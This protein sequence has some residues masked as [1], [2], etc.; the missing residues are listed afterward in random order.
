MSQYLL[1]HLSDD[2]LTNELAT[3]T[4][5]ARRCVVRNISRIA[6]YDR[7]Q[8]YLAVGYKSMYRY[9]IG[10][11]GLSED[12]AFQRIRVGR[13]ALEFPAIFELLAAGQVNPTTVLLAAPH[14]TPANAA[15]LLAAITRRTIKQVRQLLADRF[16]EAPGLESDLARTAPVTA[17]DQPAPAACEWKELPVLNPV[18][19]SFES[20][21]AQAMEPV[22]ERAATPATV[23]LPRRARLTPVSPG[24][25]ELVALL[26][27]EA[28]DQ[29]EASRELLG[30]AVP[31]GDLAEVLERAIALQFAHLRKRRCAATERP[32]K[33]APTRPTANPRRIPNAVRREVWARDGGRCAFVGTRGHRCDSRE[34]LELDHIVPV[35]R[36]GTSTTDNLRLLC[37]AHNQHV[38]ER[39]LGRD[40]MQRARETARRQ[41]ETERVAK[42]AEQERAAARK[43]ELDRQREELGEALRGLGYRGEKLGRAL[44]YCAARAEAPLEERLKYA[45]SRM[46]PNAR[47]FEAL[48]PSAPSA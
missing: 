39:A 19:P 16:G 41:R 43:A 29:L 4:S 9:C 7:R 31:S 20:I 24:C 40:T 1:R 3:S 38:A 10:K 35:A 26:G 8:L 25:Y 17:H 13:A 23:P 34:Q 2:V 44:A 27:Q 21:A 45:L 42:R 48:Q 47:R 22:C 12:V 36:G 15:E 11:L 5:E 32:R 18:A 30:H 37:R 14:L 46:A 33:P 28:S 6:E